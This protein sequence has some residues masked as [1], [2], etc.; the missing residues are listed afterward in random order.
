[1]QAKHF[2]TIAR[3]QSILVEFPTDRV[4]DF[5]EK[6]FNFYSRSARYQA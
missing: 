5:V 2:M 1:M 6:M 3:V 4:E